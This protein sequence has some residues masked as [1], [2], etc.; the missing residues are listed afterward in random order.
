M[1]E[2]AAEKAAREAA[3]EK[4]ARAAKVKK[5]ALGREKRVL[6]RSISISFN[7]VANYIEHTPSKEAVNTI[8]ANLDSIQGMLEK[9]SKID[10]QLMDF[11]D[12][13]QLTDDI[14]AEEAEI[15]DDYMKYFR[16]FNTSMGKLK[17]IQESLDPAARSSRRSMFSSTFLDATLSNPMVKLQDVPVPQFDGTYASFPDWY[18]EFSSIVDK[19]ENFDSFQKMYLLRRAMGEGAKDILKD[20]GTE[21]HLY[22]PTFKDLYKTYY[23]RRRIIAEHFANL[24]DMPPIKGNNIRESVNKVKR[25][26]RGL[27]VCDLNVDAM[28]PLIAF[29]VSRKIPEKLKMDWDTSNHDYSVY[30]SFESLATFLLNR[31]FSYETN[32]ASSNESK[33]KSSVPVTSTVPGKN[34][35]KSNSSSKSS[36]AVSSPKG[37]SVNF[38]KCVVCS[39]YHFLDQ[40]DVFIGK[41]ALERFDIIKGNKL[42]IKC[43]KPNHSVS[44]C[45]RP[46]CKSCDGK[47]HNLLHREKTTNEKP[48]NSDTQGTSNEPPKSSLCA[49][50]SSK[51]VFLSTAIVKVSDGYSSEYARVLFDQ[52]S[53]VSL[54]TREFCDRAKLKMINNP[55]PT[56]LIGINEKPIELNKVVKCVLSSRFNDF[57]IAIDA[58]VIPRIPYSVNKQD[59]KEVISNFPHNFGED[60][61][62]P[63]DS[64][65]IL[66]GSEYVEFVMAEKRFFVEG[67]CLRESKFGFVVSGSRKASFCASKMSFCGLSN[68]ELSN[69]LDRF[70]SVEEIQESELN[71]KVLDHELIEKHFNDTYQIDEESGKFVIR[72]PLKESVK[73]LNGSYDKVRKMFLR[74]ESHRSESKHNS[75]KD[76]FEEYLKLGHMSEVN[77]P[78]VDGY[79]IPHHLVS[80]I[81]TNGVSNRVV[82]NASFCDA[83]GT[84]LNNHL[85]EGPVI[86]PKL[87]TN[88]NQFRSNLVAFSTDIYR[89]YRCILIHKDDRMYQQIFFRFDR[90]GSLLV[91][92]LNTLTNGIGPASYLATKCLEKI[93]MSI[94]SS[95]PEVANIILK[96]FYMDNGTIAVKSVEQAI[97]I[98]HRLHD[99]LLKH[100]FRLTKYQSNSK[101][102]LN[103]LDPSL[104]EPLATKVIG[105]DEF[106]SLL[107]L[108]WYT[109]KDEFGILIKSSEIP[110]IATKRIILSEISKVFDILG[111]LTP[112]TIRGKLLM[113]SVWREGRKWDEEVSY[114]L[115]VEFSEYLKDLILLSE[116]RIPRC[117]FSS[118]F[119]VQTQLVGFCD[120]SL[121]AYCAVVYIRS[122]DN[123]GNIVSTFVMSKS[124]IAPIKA[125]KSNIHR[126]ELASAELLA[127]L[128]REI[129]DDLKVDEIFCFSDSMVTLGWL[130]IDPSRLKVF[131]SNRVVNVS[132]L[133]DINRW[134]Y[135]ESLSNP[136]DLGTRGI[137]SR[138]L[139][140]CSLWKIGPSW[141]ISEEFLQHVQ[142]QLDNE[143]ELPELKENTSLI[144]WYVNVLK[145]RARIR[146]AGNIP[147]PVCRIVDFKEGEWVKLVEPL[148]VEERDIAY[149][150]IIRYAQVERFEVEIECLKK[151]D[152]KFPIILSSK[153]SL[154]YLYIDFAHRKYCHASASFLYNFVRG[155]FFVIGNLAATIKECLHK[156]L[157]CTRAVHVELIEDLTTEAF[158]AT[159]E[160]FVA[161]RGLPHT[162]YSDNA[163]NFVSAR[164]R[165]FAENRIKWLL[166]SPRSPHQGGLWESAIKAGKSLMVKCI[167]SQILNLFELMT[168]LSKIEAILNSRPLA[169]VRKNDFVEP[170][171][172]GHFLIGSNLLEPSLNVDNKS[173]L[174]DRYKLWRKVVDSFWI[175]WRHEY[176]NQLRHRSKWRKE[177]RNIRIDDVVLLSLPNESSLNWPMAIVVKVYPD[178]HGTVRNAD[179]KLSDMSIRRTSVQ[180]LV[181]LPVRDDE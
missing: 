71:E 151:D 113:Q 51:S 2:T 64:V 104:I 33:N 85:L 138:K 56:S 97:A 20:M 109:D 126:L 132:K 59:I 128:I 63:H 14:V 58:E 43:F 177:G 152:A 53:E 172:P 18:A 180:R 161:R 10:S 74:S 72:L 25:V 150:R 176:F 13:A 144:I 100:G 173:S 1:T 169:Y 32:V 5:E 124:R 98:Q 62:L 147:K 45:T 91:F 141:L 154:L 50:G 87:N 69:Q 54:I 149:F 70:F 114:E 162:V 157:T 165:F 8:A 47:H 117:Y 95:D 92:V 106:V 57:H 29:I 23:N 66:L 48:D 135:V 129:S 122:I 127:K 28:S 118:S 44:N 143:R 133:T 27:N 67:L 107:G 80:K 115:F 123:E 31:S 40:C 171:T 21:G 116:F 55:S 22:E 148:S 99:V 19:N 158:L 49:L 30:P 112:V 159:F 36:L 134:F 168:I 140:N 139:L 38:P 78:N 37:S 145:S 181:L 4:A 89:M 84:S 146:L 179:V 136:A 130:H 34:A 76:V 120:A 17:T 83:S 73:C 96:S 77:E 125:S 46:N 79:F 175:C 82:F 102:F 167:G 3:A 170:V 137:P 111:I 178:C 153:S 166:I 15:C 156:C 52:G 35:G 86:Q 9:L 90:N 155:R 61:N 103:S 11:I 121:S 16:L 119:V 101:E 94:L 68:V 41:S 24:I 42:C 26:I 7:D 163:T 110:V 6:V 105:G 142:F 174:R 93:G 108:V 81:T 75:Y 160:R 60:F 39:K 131:V 164:N 88:I 12:Q 65:D